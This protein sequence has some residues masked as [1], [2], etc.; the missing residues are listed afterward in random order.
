MEARLSWGRSAFVAALFL[1]LVSCKSSGPDGDDGGGGDDGGTEPGLDADNDRL[2][3]GDENNKYH[4][5]PHDADTDDDGFDDGD[6]VLD[7][8]T[9]PLNRYSRPYI[10]DYKTGECAEYPEKPN[11]GP[12]GSRLVPTEGGDLVP[13]VIYDPRDRIL[14]ERLI[15]QYGDMVDLYSFCGVNLDILFL[16]KN[17]L[18]QPEY[19]ALSCWIT[20]L[21]QNVH[22][23]YR[24]F[25]Y[26]LVIVV[27]Q[28]DA[29]Q[30]PTR[31][32]VEAVSA[33]LGAAN[34]PVLASVD[35]SIA[36]FH[37]W[38]EKDF[39]E[40]T[41]VHIGP[42]LNVLSV[43]ND[44]CSGVDRDPCRY[45]T[46]VPEGQCWPEGPDDSCE[47]LDVDYCACPVPACED[48]CGADNCPVTY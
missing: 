32:D 44:D 35:E 33:L 39:H 38:F 40:P 36:G 10:G 9:N 25:G 5:D 18:G 4:T 13:V 24:D 17:H 22:P 15:D 30:L 28:N 23:Y 8:G 47:P 2:T 42:E 6:E 34:I 16:Q 12:T 19:P 31:D 46:T 26:Q 7:H 3:N 43:D 41:L 20:D 29:G 11:A 45:M 37:T 21:V 27:T 48:Y 1:G 14:N